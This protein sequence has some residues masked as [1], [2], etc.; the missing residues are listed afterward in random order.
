MSIAHSPINC[1]LGTS[2]PSAFIHCFALSFMCMCF[3]F[4]DVF[5]V[6]LGL[7]PC[8]VI[9]TELARWLAYSGHSVNIYFLH[10]REYQNLCTNAFFFLTILR[11]NRFGFPDL[12]QC[13]NAMHSSSITSP[14][15]HPSRE[16]PWKSCFYTS[17]GEFLFL[18][19]SFLP[20]HFVKLVCQVIWYFI[21]FVRG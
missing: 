18:G 20:K 10:W 14:L 16:F 9:Q 2:S 21:L 19:E 5:Y 3:I 4:S 8:L 1:G 6:L 15:P 11:K 12:F 13:K 17:F 7:E